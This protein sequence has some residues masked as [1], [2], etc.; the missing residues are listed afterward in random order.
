MKRRRGLNSEP[1][2]RLLAV[3]LLLSISTL[4]SSAS[5]STDDR[6]KSVEMGQAEKSDVMLSGI[7]ITC[8]SAGDLTTLRLER[9]Q[10]HFAHDFERSAKVY[11]SSPKPT[12]VIIQD[13]FASNED[14]LL[15]CDLTR[16]KSSVVTLSHSD[17]A[18]YVHMHFTVGNLHHGRVTVE[19]LEYA[20]SALPRTRTLTISVDREG[21]HVTRG[22]WSETP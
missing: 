9:G 6:L 13:C 8:R 11:V 3:G 1:F 22:S 21:Y 19:E 12:F 10:A 4:A 17:A 7:H 5:A 16:A 2:I 20:G 14:C 15:L 18:D